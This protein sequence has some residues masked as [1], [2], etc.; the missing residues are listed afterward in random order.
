MHACAQ[1]RASCIHDE[2]IS[3]FMCERARTWCL[4]TATHNCRTKILATS[5][6]VIQETNTH[7]IQKETHT[8]KQL[9]TSLT[10][11]TGHLLLST[12]SNHRRMQA[13]GCAGHKS[14]PGIN[15]L[16]CATRFISTQTYAST[17]STLFLS[18]TFSASSASCLMTGIS[19]DSPFWHLMNASLNLL[20]FSGFAKRNANNSFCC[21]TLPV[22]G[23][24]LQS[25]VK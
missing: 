10:A 14:C 24:S 1:V 16:V 22:S 2:S 23:S 21:S 3:A 5:F 13:S 25:G 20:A 17:P 8:H 18:P 15:L 6:Q 4:K 19:P 12:P 9:A 11:S 7:P